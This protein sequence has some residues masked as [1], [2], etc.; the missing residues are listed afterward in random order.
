MDELLDHR[1]LMEKNAD[2][3]KVQDYLDL[4]SEREE[5]FSDEDYFQSEACT[6]LDEEDNEI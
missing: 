1:C 5:D 4:P 6:S 2:H 3:L